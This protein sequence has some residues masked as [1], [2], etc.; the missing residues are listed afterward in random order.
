MP[1]KLKVPIISVRYSKFPT[2]QSL[3]C[4]EPAIKRHETERSGVLR[5]VASKHCTEYVLGAYGVSP[6][7]C[8]CM[9]TRSSPGPSFTLTKNNLVSGLR[10]GESSGGVPQHSVNLSPR[11]FHPACACLSQA[12]FFLLQPV[13][14]LDS[15]SRDLLL[16][17]PHLFPS[18][19]T[20][21]LN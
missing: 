6:K 13:I 19:E 18:A 8:N 5:F 2:V 4:F 1:G 17:L 10:F 9:P 15:F 12:A 21:L 20:L 7:V 16:T 3:V 11:K 14:R